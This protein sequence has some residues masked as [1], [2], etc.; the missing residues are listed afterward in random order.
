MVTTSVVRPEFVHPCPKNLFILVPTN[1]GLGFTLLRVKI[2]SYQFVTTFCTSFH[3]HN[4]CPIMFRRNLLPLSSGQ[5]NYPAGENGTCYGE[6]GVV[7]F[8]A[9]SDP[10]GTTA[11]E[12]AGLA[13]GKKRTLNTVCMCVCV[14]MYVLI[15]I[16]ILHICIVYTS[17]AVYCC[18]LLVLS[19]SATQFDC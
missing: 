13:K 18:N 1:S 15:Y 12:R 3:S 5:K 8:E 7:G 9:V 19:V 2:V 11:V 16:Y 14:R 6:G 17:A 4:V 10:M